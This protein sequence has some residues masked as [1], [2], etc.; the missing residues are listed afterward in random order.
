MTNGEKDTIWPVGIVDPAPS[1]D[2]TKGEITW[3]V[4]LGM[5]VE[6]HY[7]N[8]FTITLNVKMIIEPVVRHFQFHMGANCPNNELFIENF[9]LDIVTLISRHGA[10]WCSTTMPPLLIL[11]GKLLQQMRFW[12]QHL[13]ASPRNKS[14]SATTE[15]HK[16]ELHGDSVPFKR[17]WLL[18][19][20]WMTPIRIAN[21]LSS[22]QHTFSGPKSS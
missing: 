1:C 4:L 3:T 13:L 9:E 20:C 12:N 10:N 7:L 15:K 21:F 8:V 14:Q 19:I 5:V 2:T 17:Q 16:W 22:C 6:K 18:T 11:C